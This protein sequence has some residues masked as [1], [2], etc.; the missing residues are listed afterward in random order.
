MWSG[1]IKEFVRSLLPRSVRLHTIRRGPLRGRFI[2]TSWHDYPGA[3]LGRTELDLLGWL[4]T[5]VRNGETWLDVGAHYGYTAIALAER[6]GSTGRVFAFEPV[7]ATAGNLSTTRLLNHLDWLTVIPLGL[8]SSTG[9]CTITVP[10]E[11]GMA[12]HSAP[13]DGATQICLV[14]FD[15]IWP[16]LSGREPTIHGIKIDVQGAEHDV[17]LGMR[18]YLEEWKPKLVVE[19]HSGVDRVKF[20]D[21]LQTLGYSPEGTPVNGGHSGAPYLDDHSY[22]FLGR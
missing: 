11:R 4:E 10:I 12:Q 22:V 3:I 14:C 21:L 17:V 2:V 1:A 9:L 6:V 15:E 18:H 5:N 8:D 16:S 20:V 13:A 19:L 7:F